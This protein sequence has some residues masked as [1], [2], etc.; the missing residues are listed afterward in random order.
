MK[1]LADKLVEMEVVESIDHAT[2]WRTLKKNDLKPWLKQQRVIPPKA[3]AAFVAAM[4]DAFVAAMEDVLTLYAQPHDPFRSVVCVDDGGK[5][6]IGAVCPP[7][8]VRVGS[9]AKQDSEYQRAGMANVFLAFEP[10]AG[11][12]QVA[13]TERKTSVD[14][15]CNEPLVQ[16]NSDVNTRSSSPQ[17]AQFWHTGRFSERCQKWSRSVGPQHVADPGLRA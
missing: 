9:A 15:A 6:L 10:L 4:E 13:V 7:L 1:L 8:P 12:R 16:R 11:R 3:N 2:V 5:Q 14:F 17:I